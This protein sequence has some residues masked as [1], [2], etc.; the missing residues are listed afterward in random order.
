MCRML[1]AG[2]AGVAVAAAF[3]FT[4]LFS[5]DPDGPAIQYTAGVPHNA[6]TELNRRG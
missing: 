3:Q 2:L 6:V 1:V 5:R 4:G